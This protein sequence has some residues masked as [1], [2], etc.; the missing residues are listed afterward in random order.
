MFSSFTITDLWSLIP[1]LAILASFA[2][3]I[4]KISV[5]SAVRHER[6]DK[7]VSLLETES[8]QSLKILE[9]EYQKAVGNLDKKYSHR[10]ALALIRIEQLEGFLAKE[11]SFHRRQNVYLNDEDE[12]DTFN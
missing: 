4:N 10:S 7:R 3:W 5:N 11:S 2:F 9:L 8:K 12:G 6:I 1:N